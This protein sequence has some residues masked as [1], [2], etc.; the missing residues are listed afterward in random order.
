MATRS[1]EEDDDEDDD[2]TRP[3]PSTPSTSVGLPSSPSSV[4]TSSLVSAIEKATASL[5][6]GGAGEENVGGR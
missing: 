6:V 3:A 5:S 4:E 1:E 2:R